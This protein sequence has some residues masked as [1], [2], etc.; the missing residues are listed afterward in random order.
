MPRLPPAE[1]R[2]SNGGGRGGAGTA[3]PD[4]LVNGFSAVSPSWLSR[5]D[6]EG[7]GRVTRARIFGDLLAWLACA[8]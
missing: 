2:A 5:A 8:L 1:L 3:H 4:G 6:L 7:A